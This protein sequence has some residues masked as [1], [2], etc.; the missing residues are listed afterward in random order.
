MPQYVPKSKATD[1]DDKKTGTGDKGSSQQLPIENQNTN[2]PSSNQKK[3]KFESSKKKTD[4]LTKKLNKL[5]G[6]ISDERQETI[7]KI[8]EVNYEIDLKSEA[9]T[10]LTS[11]NKNLFKELTKLKSEVDE[12][13]KY[14]RIYKMKEE[15]IENDIKQINKYIKIQD[16]EIK[17]SKKILLLGFSKEKEYLEKFINKNSQKVLHDMEEEFKYHQELLELNEKKYKE[18]KRKTA[19]HPTCMNKINHLKERIIN[20]DSQIDF[21]KKYSDKILKKIHK[22]QKEEDSKNE[23]Y[24][25]LDDESIDERFQKNYNRNRKFNEE[26][27]KNNRG[28]SLSGIPRS[29]INIPNPNTFPDAKEIQ[30]NRELNKSIEPIW[31]EL[32]IANDRFKKHLTETSKKK[33]D[34]NNQGNNHFNSL[35]IGKEKKILSKLIPIDN[36]NDFS[37]RFNNLEREKNDIEDLLNSN[38]SKKDELKEN[39]NKIESSTLKMKEINKDYIFLK[40]ETSKLKNIIKELKKTL[41]IHETKLKEIN[42]LYNIKNKENNQLKQ[43]LDK[44]EEDIQNGELILQEQYRK[45]EEKK[46][47]NDNNEGNGDEEENENSNENNENNDEEDN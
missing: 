26:K 7:E 42:Y 10:K 16:E 21:E 37:E 12:K 41:R 15:K 24:G 33:I 45:E 4:E 18:L 38:Q 2:V 6:Q 25:Y 20:L 44:L 9:I 27:K 5:K 17:N 43:Y 8:K 46:N 31:K 23:H 34:N 13:I 32:E 19:T 36:L 11:D 30:K 28:N 40:G 1:V 14:A 22:M 35:F 39:K 3:V 29:K 47:L